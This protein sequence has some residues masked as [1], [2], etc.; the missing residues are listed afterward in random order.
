MMETSAPGIDPFPE[1]QHRRPGGSIRWAVGT[2]DGPRSQSWSLF[3]S[4]TDDVHPARSR[5]KTAFTISRRGWVS[6]RPLVA[7]G[8]SSGSISDHCASVKSLG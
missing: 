4:T 5:Y 1:P 6:A 3:G 2:L 8:G 7:G